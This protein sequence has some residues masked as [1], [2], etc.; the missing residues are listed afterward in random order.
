MNRRHAEDPIGGKDH[1]HGECRACA[2]YGKREQD[3]TSSQKRNVDL[4]PVAAGSAIDP[5]R[6]PESPGIAIQQILDIEQGD[7]HA[8]AT[9]SREQKTVPAA[10]KHGPRSEQYD[11]AVQRPWEEEPGEKSSNGGGRPRA[12][13]GSDVGLLNNSANAAMKGERKSQASNG[14]C[15]CQAPQR[16]RGKWPGH[17]NSGSVPVQ[18]ERIKPERREPCGYA[19][20]AGRNL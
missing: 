11:G 10:P 16:P 13:G 18:P 6:I 15:E 7:S 8:G 19:E 20:I 12:V 1:R 4:I 14:G 2:Q 17:R 5:E 3:E 9:V